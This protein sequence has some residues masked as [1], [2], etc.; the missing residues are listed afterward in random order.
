M[1]PLPA[2]PLESGGVA[3]FGHRL[4]AGDITAEE[5]TRAFLARIEAL[6]PRLQ[7]FE[8]V[9][10][11]YA[12][13][14]ARAVDSLRAAGTDLGPLMGVPVVFKDIIAVDGMPATAGSN[15]P[16]PDLM[17]PEGPFVKRLR[18]LGC[19]FIGKAKTVEF[20]RGASGINT[21][22]GTPRN[23]W[24]AKVH[25]VPGGSSSGSAVAVAAG[26][27]GFAMGSD[28]GGSVR[29]P[30]AFCGVLGQKT[31]KGRWP[32]AGMVP[33][34]PSFDTFGPITRSATDAALVFAA[35]DGSMPLPKRPLRGLRLGRPTSHYF[36]GMDVAVETCMTAALAALKDAGAEIVPVDVA[37]MVAARVSILQ[38]FV[39][40][41]FVSVFGRERFLA[42]M[43]RMDPLTVARSLPALDIPADACMKTLWRQR[44]LSRVYAEKLREV[45]AWVT[46]TV[47][48]VPPVVPESGDL[49]DILALEAN[50]GLN[51]HC[52]SFCGLCATTQPIHQLGSD[53]PVGLQVVCAGGDD[54][55]ALAIAGAIE[56][57]LGA[58]AKADLT[59]FP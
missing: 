34:A 22:R 9:A 51:T 20:A 31:T 57:L 47:P 39:T 1:T 50:L 29:T 46:P 49:D 43:D 41:E 44:R 54:A 30:S 2:D 24:D 55:K 18:A 23:P 7:A 58:P 27:C 17:G 32:T 56:G 13:A 33:A 52:I 19:V 35:I 5:A 21:V 11:D 15:L 42:E 3:G 48:V 8:H 10:G 53:L 40:P 6:G 36:D 37:D 38:E 45:D 14:M 25:R 28:T 4:R 59:L 12:L 16:V 26:L